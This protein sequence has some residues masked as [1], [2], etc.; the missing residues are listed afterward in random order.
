[1]KIID[2]KPANDKHHKYIVVLKDKDSIYRIKFGAY[3]MKDYTIYNSEK[4]PD[5]DKHKERYIKRH[6]KKEN[7]NDR[8]SKGFWSKHIL[9]NKP[10]IKESL[11]DVIEKYNL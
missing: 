8:L 10:T 4:N 1:M 7:W 5:A 3:G 6:Q 2:F 9:W 11:E